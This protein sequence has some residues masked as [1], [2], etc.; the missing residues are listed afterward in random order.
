MMAA[1]RKFARL[2][3]LPAPCTIV[4]SSVVVS[5]IFTI[6][7]TRF[8]GLKCEV[9]ENSQAARL[10][11]SMISSNITEDLFSVPT[12]S[13]SD[14]SYINGYPRESSGVSTGER[15]DWGTDISNSHPFCEKLI[16]EPLMAATPLCKRDDNLVCENGL[17]AGRTPFFSQVAQDYYLYTRHFKNLKREGVYLEAGTRHPVSGS[18]TYFMDACQ[19]WKGVCVE[20]N[21]ET[22]SAIHRARSCELVP[23]CVTEVDGTYL[24]FL[25][26]GESGGI[27]D[28]NK[29]KDKPT[30]RTVHTLRLR[31]MSLQVI[32]D[33]RNIKKL[34]YLSLDVEG[35]ELE[36]LKGLDHTRSIINV[37][38]I[39][40]TPESLPPIQKYLEGVGYVRHIPD[41]DERST[42]TAL[43]RDDAVFLHKDV[44]WGKPV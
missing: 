34:D 9:V 7:I 13:G 5:F 44:V 2:Q 22:L 38:T 1:M 27:E 15:A 43:L 4:L 8:S 39:E 21:P 11:S 29:N 14:L 6:V 41:L 42:R 37:M 26:N 40:S 10:M 12:H 30:E 24:N 20:G 31:C 17:Q 32:F 3:K 25:M 18:N 19:R 28:S 33:R 16:N 35:H 23:T 36:V